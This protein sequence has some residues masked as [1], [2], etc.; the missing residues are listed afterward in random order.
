MSTNRPF[1]QP[2]HHANISRMT[3]IIA[4]VTGWFLAGWM[5]GAMAAFV[6]GLPGLLAPMVAVAAALLIAYP[7]TLMALAGR[8]RRQKPAGRTS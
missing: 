8:G 1:H 2:T 4:L 3:R 5:T 6:F 7:P